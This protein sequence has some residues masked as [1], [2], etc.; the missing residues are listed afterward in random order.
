MAVLQHGKLQGDH[1]AG[2][3]QAKVRQGMTSETKHDKARQNVKM[4]PREGGKD[5]RAEAARLASWLLCRILT[6]I[7]AIAAVFSR[8]ANALRQRNLPLGAHTNVDRMAT[9]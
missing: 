3:G 1:G 8:P 5:S 4:S 7:L 2:G 6:H 9:P